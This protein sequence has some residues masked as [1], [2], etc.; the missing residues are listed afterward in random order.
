M[1][2]KLKE[3][4]RQESRVTSSETHVEP[5]AIQEAVSIRLWRLMQRRLRDQS[6]AKKLQSIRIS[7]ATF[8]TS[9]QG[10]DIDHVLS[11]E[12]DDGNSIYSR[13]E[14]FL[15]LN[16]DTDEEDLLDIRSESEWEDLFAD[17]EVAECLNDDEEM[18]DRLHVA[19]QDDDDE[20]M[21]SGDLEDD[22]SSALEEMLEL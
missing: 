15:M 1:K 10:E 21:F 6:A 19:L 14:E 4:A 9:D 20:N 11:F 22:T 18:L 8:S 3:I 16:N 13:F 7:D 12:H 17:P 5:Q 2:E